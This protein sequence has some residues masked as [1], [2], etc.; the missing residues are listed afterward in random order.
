MR[1]KLYK[2]IRDNFYKTKEGEIIPYSLYLI[3]V[4]LFPKDYFAFK[5]FDFKVYPTKKRKFLI[6]ENASTDAVTGQ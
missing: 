6:G 3:K 2:A 4:V 5:S 1:R